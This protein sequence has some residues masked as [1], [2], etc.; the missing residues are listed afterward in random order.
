LKPPGAPT[1]C[2]A[3]TAAPA[4]V[5]TAT[6]RTTLARG[7]PPTVPVRTAISVAVVEPATA[8]PRVATP[9]PGTDPP[10]GP[11]QEVPKRSRSTAPGTSASPQKLV[12]KS[13]SVHEPSADWRSRSSIGGRRRPATDFGETTPEA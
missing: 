11:P 4:G 10:P 1:G 8:V 12:P 5:A 9:W 6:F 7:T 3:T 2:W 13:S